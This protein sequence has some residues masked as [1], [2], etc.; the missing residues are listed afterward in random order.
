MA[1]P[2]PRSLARTAVKRGVVRSQR[3]WRSVGWTVVVAR[4][5]ARAVRRKPETVTVQRLRRGQGL[6]IRTSRRRSA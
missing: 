3:G 4:V 2:T 5:V 1:I 6:D